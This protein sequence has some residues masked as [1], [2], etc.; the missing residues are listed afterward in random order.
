MV[1]WLTLMLMLDKI[2]EIS[3]FVLRG[4]LDL[5]HW[6]TLGAF[7]LLVCFPWNLYEGMFGGDIL[8]K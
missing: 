4:C 2:V 7:L 6:L 3:Y 5:V 8:Q 1:V